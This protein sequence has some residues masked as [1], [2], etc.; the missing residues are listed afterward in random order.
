MKTKTYKNKDTH[1]E[2]N[3]WFG[4]ET[5]LSYAER[6]L[7]EI[8]NITYTTTNKTNKLETIKE[9][10]IAYFQEKESTQY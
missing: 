2:I 4:E 9:I 3:E 1:P 8:L 10:I 6:I 5:W 7:K